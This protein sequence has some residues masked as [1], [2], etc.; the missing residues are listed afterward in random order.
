M[1]EKLYER[2]LRCTRQGTISV[3]GALLQSMI[4]ECEKEVKNTRSVERKLL[5]YLNMAG[6]CS[7]S[8]YPYSAIRFYQ[9]V[10]ELSMTTD[11][12]NN[13]MRYQKY[14]IKAAY[15]LEA[16]WKRYTPN[17]K[18]PLDLKDVM[19]CYEDLYFLVH[20]IE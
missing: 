8:G 10:K 1:E 15:A 17:E 18:I 5:I 16:E 14:A 11:Y 9:K 6:V 7:T 20:N 19:L 13:Q 2:V 4:E 12:Q 3:N